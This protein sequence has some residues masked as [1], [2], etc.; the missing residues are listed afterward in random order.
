[1]KL[2]L[3][4]LEIFASGL[5][6]YLANSAGLV[7]LAKISGIFF[8]GGGIGMLIYASISDPGKIC[9]ARVINP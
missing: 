2:F 6:M 4:M 3:I 1:M 7:E 5:L 8:L 9:C